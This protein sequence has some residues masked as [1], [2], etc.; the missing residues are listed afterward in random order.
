MRKMVSFSYK[1]RHLTLICFILVAFGSSCKDDPK[2]KTF[3]LSNNDHADQVLKGELSFLVGDWISTNAGKTQYLYMSSSPRH[4]SLQQWNYTIAA[5]QNCS[6]RI[7]GTSIAFETKEYADEPG[8]QYTVTAAYDSISLLGGSDALDYC[9]TFASNKVVDVGATSPTAGSI[10]FGLKKNSDTSISMRGLTFTKLSPTLDS[11]TSY[12]APSP[13]TV[14]FNG[15]FVD[16]WGT[17]HLL[18][19]SDCSSLNWTRLPSSGT[20]PSGSDSETSLSVSNSFTA[21]G[22]EYR[23]S[24]DDYVVYRYTRTFY[25]ASKLIFA[26]RTLYSNSGAPEVF[27]VQTLEWNGGLTVATLK[28]YSSVLESEY[29]SGAPAGAVTRAVTY[30]KQ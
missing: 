26:T 10:T 21:D 16:D 9:K 20:P 24:H 14:L 30:T 1:R 29:Q 23:T 22:K 13:C 12:T 4:Y 7:G 8:S 19:Q 18:K 28:D 2:A 6:F 17:T 5:A 3:Q 11:P 15:R 25:A 27:R